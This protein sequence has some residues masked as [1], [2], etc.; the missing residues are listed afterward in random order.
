MP[1]ACSLLRFSVGGAVINT[2]NTKPNRTLP[3]I[4]SPLLLL[5]YTMLETLLDPAVLPWVLIVAGAAFLVIEATTPGFFMAVPGTAMIVLGLMVLAGVDIF[6][7]PVGVGVAVLA[8]IVA[9]VI[10]VLLYRRLS[11]DQEP[12]TTGRDSLIGK[13]GHVVVEVVPDTISGKVDIAGVV[14]SAKS[15]GAKIA[16]GTKIQVT[17]ASGVHITVE[18]VS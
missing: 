13:T 18:E 5:H 14:W 10:S 1:S 16:A 8:A 11:P 9:A 6:A 17:A 7:S 2:R 15:T 12:I 4:A 3:F